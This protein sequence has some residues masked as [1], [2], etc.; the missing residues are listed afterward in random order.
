MSLRVKLYWASDAHN[1]NFAV[2]A[3]RIVGGGCA[4]REEAERHALDAVE[5][6]LQSQD[7]ALEPEADEGEVEMLEL[8]IG[9]PRHV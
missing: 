5:F 4:T 6:A 7:V 2:P 1:W 8:P 9:E 3:L